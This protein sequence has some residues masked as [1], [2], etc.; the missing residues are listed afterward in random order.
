MIDTDNM[1]RLFLDFIDS[2]TDE[3]DE[4]AWKKQLSRLDELIA[5]ADF[6][7]WVKE[8]HPHYYHRLMN[9][10]ERRAKQ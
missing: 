4:R 5:V 8:T 7:S 10:Y 1:R 9:A 3:V 6:V 2:A